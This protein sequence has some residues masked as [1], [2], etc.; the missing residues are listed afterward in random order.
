MIQ[1]DPTGMHIC[2]V[3][4]LLQ[5]EHLCLKILCFL[6]NILFWNLF[7]YKMWSQ[8]GFQIV[9]RYVFCVGGRAATCIEKMYRNRLSS[10]D[11]INIIN[12]V[13]DL[14]ILWLWYGNYII[15]GCTIKGCGLP[16]CSW[17]W[18]IKRLTFLY[19]TNFWGWPIRLCS[20]SILPTLRG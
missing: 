10:V 15:C 1:M 13:V 19:N 12:W 20:L 7:M 9:D 14:K 6:L 18:T 4:Y 3:N 5:M 2:L 8:N 11:N 17:A 16:F